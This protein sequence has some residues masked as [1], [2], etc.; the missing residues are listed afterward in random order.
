MKHKIGKE[1]LEGGFYIENREVRE[2]SQKWYF[3]EDL[4]EVS[5]GLADIRGLSIPGAEVKR[6]CAS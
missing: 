3:S 2:I 4:K 1:V 5:T 6:R